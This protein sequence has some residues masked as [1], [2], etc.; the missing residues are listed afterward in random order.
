MSD[1]RRRAFQWVGLTVAAAV[2][3]AAV[4]AVPGIS[5]PS[6]LTKRTAKQLFYTKAKS[7]ARYYTKAQSDGRY[8]SKSDSDDRYYSKT[9]SDDRYYT[10]AD[11][12]ARYVPD[13][14]ETRISFSP[15]QW[16]KTNPVSPVQVNNQASDTSFTSGVAD[17]TFIASLGGTLPVVLEGRPMNLVG[18]NA[19][20]A[21]PN[22]PTLEAV[23]VHIQDT[24]TNNT[25][26]VITDSTER[27]DDACRDYLASSP[28]PLDATDTVYVT[29][30][31]DFPGGGGQTFIAQRVT[32]ILEP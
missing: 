25:Q 17:N 31:V 24:A 1:I 2:V 9:E 3:V 6:F 27:S 19:C 12:D 14:G 20:Y 13:G 16:Q 5:A 18:V 29:Y 4:V 22:T 30:L 11:S 23:Q 7:D 21:T 10:K 8:Y 26:T 32:V 28:I 15:A